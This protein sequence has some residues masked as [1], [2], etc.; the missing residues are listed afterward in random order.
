MET[1][2][3]TIEAFK[4]ILSEVSAHDL[5][6]EPRSIDVYSFDE[7]CKKRL[8]YY[9]DSVPGDVW[10]GVNFFKKDGYSIKIKEKN[11]H[12]GIFPIDVEFSTL[13]DNY[14]SKS[15][16]FVFN[17]KRKKYDELLEIYLKKGLHGNEDRYYGWGDSDWGGICAKMKTYAISYGQILF[18]LTKE[19]YDGLVKLYL[20]KLRKLDLEFLESKINKN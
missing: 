11:C 19:E 16:K 13:F 9:K 10:C 14:K 8:K 18:E 20:G 2:N 3:K 17:V 4:T 6:R 7:K 12:I 5:I 1:K 15:T